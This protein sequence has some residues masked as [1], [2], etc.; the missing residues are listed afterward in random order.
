MFQI[1]PACLQESRRSQLL[2]TLSLSLELQLP[3]PNQRSRTVGPAYSQVTMGTVHREDL[4]G[5]WS[6][7]PLGC[8]LLCSNASQL[9]PHV[10]VTRGYLRVLTPR[11]TLGS[12]KQLSGTRAP[13][14]GHVEISPS[15]SNVFP[16]LRTTV[17][18]GTPPSPGPRPWEIWLPPP[19]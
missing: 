18:Q 4:L 1:L 3:L 15:D 16:G 9:Q 8:S 2:L 10:T 11:P 5:G 6:W 13:A 19:H 17:F 7:V 14:L 12:Q